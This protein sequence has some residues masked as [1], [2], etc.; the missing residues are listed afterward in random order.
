LN[1]VKLIP[2][3]FLSHRIYPTQSSYP[4]TSQFSLEYVI[5]LHFL[6]FFFQPHFYGVE[7]SGHITS[8]KYVPVG[9]YKPPSLNG[10]GILLPPKMTARSPLPRTILHGHHSTY[11]FSFSYLQMRPV[12]RP[13]GIWGFKGHLWDSPKRGEKFVVDPHS[14]PDLKKIRL[15]SDH[16]NVQN[17]KKTIKWYSL[18][19]KFTSRDD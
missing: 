16:S 3:C 6:I 5:C 15:T 11:H 9:R 12:A 14:T 10:C 2:S 17:N 19:T 1:T 4:C 8:Y 7:T 13:R 18:C